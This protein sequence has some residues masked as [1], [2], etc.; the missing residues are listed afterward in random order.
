MFDSVVNTIN[1]ILDLLGKGSQ[2]KK[3]NLEIQKLEHE[4]REAK[5]V[6][7]KPDAKEIQQYDP[8]LQELLKRIE[9][10]LFHCYYRRARDDKSEAED[11]L[12]EVF[13]RAYT[14]LRCANR[15]LSRK[16]SSGRVTQRGRGKQRPATA[17]AKSQVRRTTPKRYPR[18][19]GD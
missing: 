13:Q 12:Q 11:V 15:D 14:D 5:S 4:L 17:P 6:I 1:R 9:N 19:R 2:A 8:K 7:Q 18:R 3:C 16:L 10:D